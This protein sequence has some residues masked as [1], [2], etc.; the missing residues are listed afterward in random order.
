MTQ[1]DKYVSVLGPPQLTLCRFWSRC[2]RLRCPLARL[3]GLQCFNMDHNGHGINLY[4][5]VVILMENLHAG[6][7]SNL[8]HL[9][10]VHRSRGAKYSWFNYGV[11]VDEVGSKLSFRD[12]ISLVSLGDSPEFTPDARL[13]IIW[14][15]QFHLKMMLMTLTSVSRI[16]IGISTDP[17]M[18]FEYSDLIHYMHSLI[19]RGYSMANSFSLCGVQLVKVL[20][21]VVKQNLVNIIVIYYSPCVFEITHNKMFSPNMDF[22]PTK[23]ILTFTVV[24]YE[25]TLLLCHTDGV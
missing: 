12:D 7:R 23:L 9:S 24:P 21:H 14:M 2:N 16:W 3:S 15:T 10:L 19:P 4:G 25:Y 18:E 11:V 22:N 20:W 5:V 13:M 17:Q 8:G 1:V 6:G